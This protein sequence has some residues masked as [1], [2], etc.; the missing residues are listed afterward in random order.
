[1]E[2]GKCCTVHSDPTSGRAAF[3]VG[4]LC[5]TFLPARIYVGD[6]SG[7]ACTISG[8]LV[9]AGSWGTHQVSA[10][11]FSLPGILSSS[12][13]FGSLGVEQRCPCLACRIA[14]L[15]AKDAIEPVPPAEIKS[16]FYSP[17]LHRTQER[18]WV[19]T[20]SWTC[21]FWTG[22]FTSSRSGCWRRDAFFNAST[23]S[24][25]LQQSTWRTPP[26]MSRSSLDTDRSFSAL[27]SKDEHIR[28]K[29][30][31]RAI[32]VASYLQQVRGGSPCSV[33]GSRHSHSQLPR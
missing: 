10:T 2:P 16:G 14:V 8:G 28:Y 12:G 21:A 7:P 31:P 23:F 9:R 4:L 15:V 11:R 30:T 19:T 17:L 1:M 25:G 18:R 27:R 6:S 32:P 22:P 24:I 3:R 13:T 33:K 20:Q 26:Y 5:S 29:A